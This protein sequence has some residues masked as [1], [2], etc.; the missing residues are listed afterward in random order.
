MAKKKKKRKS[1]LIHI[2]DPVF[3][4]NYYVSYG[5]SRKDF[6]K[7]FKEHSD[8]NV[9][10]KP[11]TIGAIRVIEANDHSHEIIWIWTETKKLSIL[12][13][14]VFHAAVRGIGYRINTD[15]F[16]ENDEPFAYIAEM[17]VRKVLE[18]DG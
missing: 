2:W 3:K 10:L 8:I 15:N 6:I 17:I 13:H 11:S 5:V 9:V 16:V 12:F 4:Q 18:E 7:Q 14:E 1:K